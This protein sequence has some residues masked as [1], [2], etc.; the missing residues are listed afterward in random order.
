MRS[1][2]QNAVKRIR[3]RLAPDPGEGVGGSGEKIQVG[4][5]PPTDP[6]FYKN[7]SK[8]NSKEIIKTANAALSQILTLA[9][10]LLGGTITFW[11][12]I[13][14]TEPYNF[15][16][17]ALLLVTITIC[18]FSAMPVFGRYDQTSPDDIR[19]FMEYVIQQKKH[20][21]NIAKVALF[22]CILAMIVGLIATTLHD[23]SGSC[24]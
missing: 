14:L 11:K 12:T 15:I 21:L 13:P 3:S 7:W 18:L 9:T 4:R 17:L 19:D 20:R 5:A 8:E 16:V 2:V 24:K 1:N 6:E 23:V 10:A 22:V